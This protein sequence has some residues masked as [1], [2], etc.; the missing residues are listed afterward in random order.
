MIATMPWP[1]ALLEL[2]AI[3]CML[4][5]SAVM[6]CARRPIPYRCGILVAI[7]GIAFVLAANTLLWARG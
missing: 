7:A 4:A 6:I 1:I 5:G 3:G 2:I